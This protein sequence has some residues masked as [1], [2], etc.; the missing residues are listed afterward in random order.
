MGEEKRKSNLGT[1]QRAETILLTAGWWLL[2]T[3][4]EGGGY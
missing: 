3:A 1:S 2:L 4:V